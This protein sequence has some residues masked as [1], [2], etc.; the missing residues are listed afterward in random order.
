MSTFIERKNTLQL[1][2]KL[3]VFMRVLAW[4]VAGM[5]LLTVLFITNII[6]IGI[7]KEKR[8][9]P[10][11][12]ISPRSTWLPPDRVSIPSGKEG[13][14]IRYGEELIR[15]TAVYLGPKGKVKP[16]SNG[17]NCN[18][19]HLNGG[20]QLYGLNFSAVASTYPK[21][22]NRSGTII[23]VKERINECIERSLNG[24]RLMPDD[25]ELNAMAAYILWIG[26]DVTRKILEEKIV[27]KEIGILDRAADPVKGKMVFEKSCIECHDQHGDGKL[28]PSGLEYEYPPLFGD[29]S[30]NVGAGLYRL[31]RFASFVKYNMPFGTDYRNPKLT[32]EEAWD[33]AAYINSLPRPEKDLSRDWPELS[34]KPFDHP[35][36]PYSDEYSETQHKYGPWRSILKRQAN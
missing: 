31:S 1:L 5:F 19:C 8:I 34:D 24:E 26:K 30:Y 28:H 22:R 33:V 14:L 2:K 11:D 29:K 10:K 13:E 12:Y 27:V 15:H 9:N 16:I 18:N 3:L 25:K 35:F 21:F 6:P 4:L 32:D 20:T 17:M 36:G 23:D 7:F